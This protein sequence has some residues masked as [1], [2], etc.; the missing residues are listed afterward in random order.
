[1]R[2]V[3]SIWFPRL[4]LDRRVRQGDPQT[5]GPF[6]IIAE[7]KNAWRLTHVN[8]LALRAGVTAGLSLPD[9]RAICPDLLTEPADQMR[10]AALLSSLQ[11]WSD[12]LSPWVAPDAP[13]GLYLDISGC[14]HLFGGEQTMAEEALARLNDMRIAARIGIADTKGG[15]NA[16]ARFSTTQITIA[17]CGKTRHAL[18]SLPIAALQIDTSVVAEL[19]ST[20][21]KTIGQLYEIKSNELARRF[22]LGIT[23]ALGTSLGQEPDPIAPASATPIYA[24]R[25]T[26]PEPIGLV[27]DLNAVLER[28]SMSVCT[29][30]ND[31]QKGAR[32]FKLTVRCVDT[33]DH[34]LKVGFSKPC[35]ATKLVVQQFAHPLDKLEIEFGADWFRLVAE[36]IEALHPKQTEF[37]EKPLERESNERLKTTLSNRLGADRVQQFAGHDSHLPECEFGHVEAIDQASEPVWID[38]PRKRP[39]RVYQRPKQLLMLEPGRPPKRFQWRRAVYS[40]KRAK[41]PERLTAEWWRDG[42]KRARDYWIVHTDNGS[43]LWLLTY[44]GESPPQWYLAGKFP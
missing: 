2:R 33:G 43:S 27:S 42:D 37:G 39:L 21:I 41:G 25:M 1:M 22:G 17:E 32:R 14:A 7:S 36:Q 28:L 4:P 11:R 18:K 35:A 23:H 5:E 9:A 8:E 30:L 15:A 34:V 19:A 26:V 16:L 20:G 29:R 10:E 12:V 40:V 31:D 24:A 44:P 3:L 38:A 13:D 6:A